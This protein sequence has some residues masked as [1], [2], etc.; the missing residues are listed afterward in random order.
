MIVTVVASADEFNQSLNAARTGALSDVLIDCAGGVIG[1]LLVAVRLLLR[2]R[3]TSS[4]PS[5][6][7]R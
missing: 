4:R 1:I 2:Q 3:F 7:T 5:Q 6:T